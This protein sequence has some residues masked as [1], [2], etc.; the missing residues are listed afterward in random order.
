MTK[1]LS[2]LFFI[3]LLNSTTV[4]CK[5]PCEARNVQPTVGRS[6]SKF[7]DFFES[8]ACREVK[9]N[10]LSDKITKEYCDAVSSCKSYQ[11]AKSILPSDDLDLLD[12]ESLDILVRE[13][14]KAEMLKYNSRKSKDVNELMAYIDQMPTAFKK[15]VKGCEKIDTL[16]ID[17]CLGDTSSSGMVRYYIENTLNKETIVQFSTKGRMQNVDQTRRFNGGIKQMSFSRILN[18]DSEL[19]KQSFNNNSEHDSLLNSIYESVMSN[20]SKDIKEIKKI[21]RQKLMSATISGDDYILKFDNDK[22]LSIIDKSLAEIKSFGNDFSPNNPESKK[23]LLD[24]INNIRIQLAN[25]HF[26]ENCGSTVRSL[27][28]VCSNI[29]KN[30]KSGKTLD[31]LSES[32]SNS[33]SVIDPFDQMIEYYKNSNIAEKEKKINTLKM[34]RNAESK[35]YHKFLQYTLQTEVCTD[36]FGDKGKTRTERK[37]QAVIDKLAEM[38]KSTTKSREEAI[39]AIADVAK[40]DRTFKEEMD[41]LGIKFDNDSISNSSVAS[42]AKGADQSIIKQNIQSETRAADSSFEQ[43]VST[44]ENNQGQNGIVGSS[45]ESRPFDNYK[46]YGNFD[47]YKKEKDSSVDTRDLRSM[48]ESLTEQEKIMTQKAAMAKDKSNNL[49]SPKTN[50]EIDD[51]RRQVDELKKS[52][53]TGVEA[54]SLDRDNVA[55]KSHNPKASNNTTSKNSFNDIDDSKMDVSNNVSSPNK[56]TASHFESGA[57]QSE[58]AAKSYRASSDK[59]AKGIILSKSGEVMQDPNAILDNPKEGEIVRLL[60][61]TNGQPFIIRENGVLIKIT[62]ELDTFGKPQIF[63]GKPRYK[64]ERLTKAQEESIEKFANL[65]KAMKEITGSPVRLFDLKALLN[66]SIKRE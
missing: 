20:K 51:L 32:S 64:K 30:I 39:F 8:L 23:T 15:E 43:K 44:T 17:A 35:V 61:A 37:S 56:G 24:K 50:D 42:N 2:I 62:L 34:M 60:E 53:V 66:N 14:T 27:R 10:I 21:I 12:A 1:N 9:E 33:K 31:L 3:F 58:A 7:L 28:H 19:V 46:N 59:S 57:S 65:P 13:T 4:Y 16:D 38:D 40:S 6:Q 26:R 5:V 36:K 55:F 18:E 41:K 25:S 29:T 63:S 47:S 52:Q 45:S 54:K 22:T 48:R 49:S 11:Q